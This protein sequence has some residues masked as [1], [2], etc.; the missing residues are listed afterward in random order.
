[1]GAQE[2]RALG[3]RPD[4]TQETIAQNRASTD[5][6]IGVKSCLDEWPEDTTGGRGPFAHL[7]DCTKNV[8]K[9]NN[10]L[11]IK[12][13]INQNLKKSTIRS[14]FIFDLKLFFGN[15]LDYEYGSISTQLGHGLVG[16]S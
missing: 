14:V 8:E 1:M 12:Q 2:I 6:I 11:S 3:Q 10:S 15:V 5:T 9:S 4:I 7:N 16:L 13:S